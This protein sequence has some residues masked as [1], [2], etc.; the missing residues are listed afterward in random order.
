VIALSLMITACS[1]SGGESDRGDIRAQSNDQA[2][3]RTPTANPTPFTLFQPSPTPTLSPTVNPTAP[4]ET[5]PEIVRTQLVDAVDGLLR[6]EPG[7]YGVVIL[8]AT[9][10]YQYARNSDLPFVSA[11]LY[12]LVLLADVYQKI[13]SGEISLTDTIKLREEFFEGEDASEDGYFSP[14]DVNSDVTIEEVVYATGAYSSNVAAEALLSLTNQARLE[15]MAR[16]IGMNHTHFR[17]RPQNIDGWPGVLASPDDQDAME[18]VAFCEAQA[19]IGPIN[20]TTPNDIATYF[21]KLLSGQVVSHDAS[22]GIINVLAQQVVG[23]RLPWFIPGV[24]IAHKTGNLDHVV[25]D[26]GI[27]YASEDPIIIAALSEGQ[28]DDDHATQVIQR[29]GLIATGTFEIPP[30]T[31][32]AISS[33]QPEMTSEASGPESDQT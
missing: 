15:R 11:S 9:G 17:T 8:D 24:P 14:G 5:T 26:A 16:Q 18:A 28:P 4:V 1:L 27:I 22:A 20:V 13:E 21:R 10:D 7:V 3:V 30:F 12:K 2:A 33:P 29:L 25:H 32:T 19:A 23:D 31:E 6:E